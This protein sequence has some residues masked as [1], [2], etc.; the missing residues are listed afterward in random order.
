MKVAIATDGS[1]VS[2]HFGRCEKYEVA[3]I[4]DGQ[5]TDRQTVANP[6][7]QPGA[8]PTMLHGLGVETIIC[9]GAG[10]RAVALFE[11]FGINVLMGVSGPVD[12]ALEALASGELEVG[13]STCDH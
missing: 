13:E 2:G 9:G 5:V 12:K 3:T 4:T 1:Q 10:P 7:H 11:Q 8:L 6:G